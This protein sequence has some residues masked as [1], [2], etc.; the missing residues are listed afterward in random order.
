MSFLKPYLITYRLNDGKTHVR[1]DFERKRYVAYSY[2]GIDLSSDSLS[3]GS[4]L[5]LRSE[6]RK[7]L[8]QIKNY[9]RRTLNTLKES[10][11]SMT[12]SEMPDGNVFVYG[13]VGDKL[14]DIMLNDNHVF[15]ILT[16]PSDDL[17][18][19]LTYFPDFPYD[20]NYFEGPGINPDDIFFNVDPTEIVRKIATSP[21]GSILISIP[22]EDL[23]NGNAF[24]NEGMVKYAYVKG[25][26]FPA[27]KDS[28]GTIYVGDIFD[29]ETIQYEIQENKTPSRT[30][31]SKKNQPFS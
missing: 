9:A 4:R 24:F 12:K 7:R 22:N 2:K 21:T 14:L 3:L 27:Q 1:Y 10:G 25:Y 26:M 30:L 23:E 18:E 19:V 6:T 16:P 11:L 5:R 15:G 28:R 20:P 8:I 13:N 17:T 31:I 29:R